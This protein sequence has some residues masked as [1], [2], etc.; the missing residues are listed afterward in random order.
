MTT[1]NEQHFLS[2]TELAEYLG[3]PVQ[4]VYA[5]RHYGTGPR[6]SKVGRH[7]RYRRTDVDAWFDANADR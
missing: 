7:V 6:S 1:T 2:P 3:V 4:T 5:W